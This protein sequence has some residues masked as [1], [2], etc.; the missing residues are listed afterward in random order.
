MAWRRARRRDAPDTIDACRATPRAACAACAVREGYLGASGSGRSAAAQRRSA[1]R[2]VGAVQ[3]ARR[4]LRVSGEEE[5]AAGAL[6]RAG[7]ARTITAPSVTYRKDIVYTCFPRKRVHPTGGRGQ[8]PPP[9]PAGLSRRCTGCP[10]W[11]PHSALWWTPPWTRPLDE[12]GRPVS[13]SIRAEGARAARGRAMAM[14]VVCS[15]SCSS[16]TPSSRNA[17]PLPAPAGAVPG[18]LRCH[19]SVI[20]PSIAAARASHVAPRGSPQFRYRRARKIPEEPGRP[21]DPQHRGR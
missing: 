17:L 6:L 15:P 2:H 1:G 5:A 18:L 11:T 7:D 4:E 20:A 10:P 14:W 3:G 12:A 21:H 16:S 19:V 9:A 8:R 13:R